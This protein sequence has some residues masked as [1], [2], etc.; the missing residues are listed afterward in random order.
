MKQ[1]LYVLLASTLAFSLAACG[2]KGKLK[3]PEQIEAEAAKKVHE[4]NKPAAGGKAKDVEEQEEQIYVS[5]PKLKPNL[6]NNLNETR[7]LSPSVGN[8]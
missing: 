8:Y 1:V 2:H 4:E 6:G 5:P 7:P 3:S